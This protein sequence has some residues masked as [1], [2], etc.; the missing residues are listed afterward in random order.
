MFVCCECMLI[1]LI[2]DGSY[3]YGTT[4]LAAI[5]SRSTMDRVIY[6]VDASQVCIVIV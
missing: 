4:D 6:V 2:V 3:L 5:E 1:M